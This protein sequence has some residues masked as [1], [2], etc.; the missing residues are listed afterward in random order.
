M[1]G[2]GDFKTP[3]QGIPI[4]RPEG[5][6]EFNT[7]INDSWGY[8]PND[9]NYKSVPQLV[10]MFAECIGMGGNMLLDVGPMAD[11]TIPPEQ[12]ERLEGLG[13]CTR[14]PVD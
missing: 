12:V 7:T 4:E 11:G 6:W 2:C 14:R 3:E 5:V 8:K 10:R 1:R 9:T 13:A